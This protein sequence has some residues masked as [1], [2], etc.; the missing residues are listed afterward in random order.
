MQFVYTALTWGFLLALVPLAIHL[1]NMMRH[2]R[3]RWAAMDFLLASYKKHR[4]WIWLKQL[5]LLL[6]RMA[7]VALVVAMLAKLVSRNQ[8]SALLGSKATHHFVLLDDSYSM[9][10]RTGAATAFDA[11]GQVMAR[12]AAEAGQSDFQHKFTLLRYSQALSNGSAGGNG[13]DKPADTL[14]DFNAETVDA[15]FDV[16]LEEKRRGFEVTELSIGPTA[17]LQLIRQFVTDATQ[18][19]NIVY[20]LSDFRAID[21][22]A[23]TAAKEALKQLQASGAE[24]RF[25]RC[26]RNAQANLGIEAIEPTGDTRAAGVPLFVNVTVRNHGD[27]AVRRVQV[28]LRTTFFDASQLN[29][30]APQ[31]NVGVSE[32]LPVVLIDEIPPGETATERVQVYFPAPGQHVVEATLPDDPIAADNHRFSVI[33]F[34]AG[35]PVLVI[36]G[37]AQQRNAFYLTSAFEPGA[38][39]NTGIRPEVQS[40]D[41]LRDTTAAALQ[42]FRTIYLLDVPQLDARGVKNLEAY[43][44]GGG[45]LG[46]FLGPNVNYA[47]Y[48]STLYRAGQGLLPAPL[49]REDELLADPIEHKPDIEAERH[50]IFAPLLDEQNPLIRL[51][52]IE[53]YVR[54]PASWQPAKDGTARVLARLRNLAPLAIEQAYGEGRV[55]LFTTTAA[56]DWNGW[57][58]DPTFVV[59]ALKLQSYLARPPASDQARRVGTPIVVELETSR[60]R[61]EVKFLVPGPRAGNRIVIERATAPPTDATTFTVAVGQSPTSPTGIGE[62]GRAGYYDAWPTTLEGQVTPRRLALN[63]EPREG[64]LALLEPS[65]I[66]SKL[67]PAKIEFSHF[68][69]DLGVTGDAGNNLSLPLLGLLVALLLGEQLLAYSASYHSLPQMVH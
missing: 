3:V 7:A 33:D 18:D 52:N 64:H 13:Q 21:W 5:L 49:D 11:A 22:E 36:D 60:Y 24:V 61:P 16:R 34:P 6:M 40:P 43:V 26:V 10:D 23:P 14:L 45:G 63:V 42:R 56:P 62:T 46:I 47:S 35:E 17:A 1:I 41:Y 58:N 2:H 9:S 59:L 12:I 50:P 53:R 57:A 32:D 29:T 15:N 54:V 4:K 30:A 67:A 65:A 28:K 27:Q 25:V 20:V 39:A 51:V 68:D 19:Q 44:R 38:R 8:W 69:D 66:T 37:N 48:N 31:A 55:V